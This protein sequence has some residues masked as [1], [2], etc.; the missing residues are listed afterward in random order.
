MLYPTRITN[1]I[2]TI[3]VLSLLACSFVGM[4]KPPVIHLQKGHQQI[5]LFGT[6]HISTPE[7]IAMLDDAV[8]ELSR[9]DALAVEIDMTDMSIMPATAMAL[10]EYGQ[11]E[12]SSLSQ[13]LGA[14]RVQAI[15]KLLGEGNLQDIQHFRPW[16]LAVQ[17]IISQAEELGYDNKAID[18][19]LVSKAKE[20][21]ISVISLEE[22][23]EQLAVFGQLSMPEELQMID[24]ALSEDGLLELQQGVDL[25]KQRDTETAKKLLTAMQE[26]NANLYKAIYQDRNLTM[27]DKIIAINA[28]KH[29]LFVAVGALH[30]YGKYSLIELLQQHGYSLRED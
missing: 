11:L 7:F 30:L 1:F 21:S 19:I 18:D 24:E 27:V 16:V 20:Q 14:K 17:L 28:D 29:K 4:A 10:M 22:P 26:R 25:W 5:A 8:A 12:G 15:E 9:A 2:R 23:A 6:I 13:V 3:I